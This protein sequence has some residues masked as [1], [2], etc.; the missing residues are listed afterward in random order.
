MYNSTGLTLSKTLA[1][2]EI[3]TSWQD[4]T[5]VGKKF[6]T[7]IVPLIVQKNNM[8]ILM[9]CLGNI[10]RSPMAE[11]VMRHK[12][13][14]HGLKGFVDSAG[15]ASYHVGENPDPRAVAKARH[16]GISIGSLV[17][18]QFTVSDFDDFDRIYV[19]DTS[20]LQNINRLAR[21]NADKQKVSLL[22]N[23]LYPGQNMSVPD[24]YYGGDE[25]FENVYRLLDKVCE[26]ICTQLKNT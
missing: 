15:T 6:L 9:V 23:E 20:N 11:G 1:L 2:H 19:M 13:E 12:M 8:K 18:R 26:H 22:M 16:Y 21:T 5:P 14:Q 4:N 24:P 3:K 10:C 7:I 25:G 17:G